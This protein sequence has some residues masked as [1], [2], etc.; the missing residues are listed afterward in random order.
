MQTASQFTINNPSKSK[1]LTRNQKNNVFQHIRTHNKCSH[2]SLN[3]AEAQNHEIIYI[4]SSSPNEQSQR[5]K[6]IIL[7]LISGMFELEDYYLD[8]CFQQILLEF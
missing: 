1:Y 8:I 7:I 4:F 6:K 3:K 5:S 2:R